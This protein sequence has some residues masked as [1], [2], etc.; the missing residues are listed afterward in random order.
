M[1]LH[2]SKFS[3]QKLDGNHTDGIKE[4]VF[5][6]EKN[7]IMEQQ[8]PTEIWKLV[9]RCDTLFWEWAGVLC[10]ITNTTTK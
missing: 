4:D 7:Y 1:N 5:A 3:Q 10:Q 9:L 6:K 8:A 2:L